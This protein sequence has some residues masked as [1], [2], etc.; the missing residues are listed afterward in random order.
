[1]PLYDYHCAGCGPFR[2]WRSM[3]GARDP[4]PCPACEEPGRRTVAAPSLALMASTQRVA[5][6]RNE[7][8]AHEPR[9][10][11]RPSGGHQHGHSHG[12]GHSHHHHHLGRP[13]MIGH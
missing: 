1:M 6:Q 4:V 8:S 5:H 9:L 3:Q 10:E 11:S 7:K 12:H 2:A 13:W